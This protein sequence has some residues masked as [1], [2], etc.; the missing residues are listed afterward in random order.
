MLVTSPFITL[1]YYNLQLAMINSLSVLL[2]ITYNL[3]IY[4]Y[5]LDNHCVRKIIINHYFL[6]LFM[7]LFCLCFFS[8]ASLTHILGISLSLSLSLSPH[9]IKN[10]NSFS[11]TQNNLRINQSIPH[12]TSRR[13]SPED[14]IH[15]IIQNM[16]SFL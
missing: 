10:K 1:Y 11:N 6:L 14:F 2:V 4:S 13:H 3:Y 15:V 7:T 12:S 5:K 8:P 9:V 16:I